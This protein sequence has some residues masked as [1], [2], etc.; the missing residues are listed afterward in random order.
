MNKLVKPF[1]VISLSALFIA[2]CG[3]AEQSAEKTPAKTVTAPDNTEKEQAN[4][5]ET[6]EQKQSEDKGDDGVIRIL[7]QNL[8]YKVNGE[9]KEETAFLKYNDNQN[10]SMYVLP[11]YELTGEE[12]N[13]D[14]LF[15]K[16]DD[17]VFMRIELLP[18]D[19]DWALMEENTKA[20]L[21][22]VGPDV[23]E[24]EIPD[25][26]FFENA[27]AMET[28][29]GSETVTSY[30]IKNEQQPIKLTLFTKD[31]AD[32]RNAFLEM[33]KTILKENK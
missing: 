22:A 8:S 1:A 2:G 19:I 17:S 13:K 31:N 28:K 5:Q 6:S 23:K 4:G 7:E 11:E 29:S 26:T 27:W 15:W 3:S 12:P 32:H 24:A 10:Y 14:V 18:A 20:Q 33:G 16:D 30:L 9:Q 21:T 25:D